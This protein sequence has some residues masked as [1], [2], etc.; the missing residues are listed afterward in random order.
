MLI[1]DIK[2]L[3]LVYQCSSFQASTEA[4]PGLHGI[5]VAIMLVFISAGI[6]V[7]AMAAQYC[8]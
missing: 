3:S 8:M 5:V 2:L 4:Q 7:L 6:L 1:L